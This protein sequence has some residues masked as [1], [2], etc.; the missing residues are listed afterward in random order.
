MYRGSLLAE[1]EF[2]K[3]KNVIIEE[4]NMY[5]DSPDD[6][7]MDLF[8]QTLWP[9]HP[10]GRPVAGSL[11]SVGALSRDQLAAYWHDTYHAGRTVIAV[12]GNVTM[13]QVLPLVERY[14]G[15]FEAAS[16]AQACL[17]ATVSTGKRYAYIHKDIE[18]TH[19][20]MGFPALGAADADYYAAMVLAN[21]LGGGASSRLF[22]EVREKRGLS[23]SAYAYLDAYR[24]GGCLTAYASTRPAN[25][26]EL[27]AAIAQEYAQVARRGITEAELQRSKDQ[28]KGSL[29]LS[30]ENS[31][32]MMN[33]LGRFELSL[34]RIVP[35]EETVAQLLAVDQAAIEAV[36]QRIIVPER[37]CVAM[38]GPEEYA[39]D[40]AA[41]LPGIGG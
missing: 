26:Q 37:L 9:Q 34:G 19:L 23:Y 17:P 15:D 27:V 36:L 11:R 24:Q 7:V 20:C 6:L 41:L 13:D 14:F 40:V 38:V 35:P 31:S 28:L 21:A 4:I 29:L 18:Q 16:G 1:E 12:A 5:E 22:Q 33:R 25:I 2:A 8:C 30:L 32:N 3:E 39:V 10:Y